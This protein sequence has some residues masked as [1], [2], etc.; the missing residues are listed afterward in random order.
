MFK[1]DLEK[2]G[3]AVSKHSENIKGFGF[4]AKNLAEN[5]KKL[6]GFEPP[7]PQLF[8]CMQ[9]SSSRHLC[10]LYQWI[11]RQGAHISTTPQAGT[12]TDTPGKTQINT[13]TFS[14]NF[15]C[16]RAQICRVIGYKFPDV[17]A[18]EVQRGCLGLQI[19]LTN[20]IG[21]IICA[22]SPWFQNILLCLWMV[23]ENFTPM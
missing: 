1:H 22:E 7:D 19:T 16:V 5:P 14:D 11:W 8:G 15:F 10:S 4:S 6:A 13:A 9:P 12:T 20:V 2:I 21:H 23:V 18:G 17:A 3:S